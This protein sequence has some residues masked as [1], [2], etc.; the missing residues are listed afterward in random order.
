[1][2]ALL[3][4]DSTLAIDNISQVLETAGYD[5]I[6]Y[7]WLLKA[8]DNIEE[9]APHLIVVSTKDYPRHWKT[10][11]QFASTTFSSY[12]PE[13]VLYAEGGL[14]EDELNKAKA[15]NIRGIFESVDVNGLDVLR[16]I[17]AKEPDI[18]SGTLLEEEFRE[19]EI[20]TVDNLLADKEGE[21]EN[22]ETTAEAEENTTVENETTQIEETAMNEENLTSEKAATEETAEN[23]QP[24]S[25]ICSFMFTNP[26]SGQLVTG[27]A[28]N[29][30]GKSFIFKADIPS[31]TENLSFGTEI[32]SGSLKLNDEIQ[33][34]QT[35]VRQN[36]SNLVL[37]L[38]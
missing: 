31:F 34:V 15:L 7:K 6:I 2:K 35:Q 25:I 13:I 33:C 27:Y 18:Y 23:S 36:E 32:C 3:V 17:L 22:S 10:L 5:V 9:I 14:T 19:N 30:D 4:A 16:K 8:L 1:M 37:E 12:R 11:A 24:E 28:Y 26:V 20:P 29:F 38:L 21:T